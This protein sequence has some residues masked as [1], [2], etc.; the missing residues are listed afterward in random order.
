MKPAGDQ[1]RPFHD[2]PGAGYSSAGQLEQVLRG[3]HF[4]VTAELSP[5]DSADPADVYQRASY[6]D[7][8]VDAI[9]ATDGSGANCH[10]SSVGV[11]SLLTRSGYSTVMQISCRDRNRIAIQGDVLGA[12]A[13]GV[14]NIL[15]LTGDGVQAGDQPDAKG[16]FDFDC[17]S[18]L[19]TVCCMRDESRFLSDRKL[20]SPPKVFVGAAANPYAPPLDYRPYRLKKKIEAGAQF[21][22]TQYCFDVPRLRKYMSQ[23]CDLGLHERCFILVGVGPLVSARAAEWIRTNVPGVCIPD[24]VISRLKS[25]RDPRREGTAVCIELMQE[26]R[27][28]EGV[29]GL[30]IMAYRQEQSIG[31][32]IQSSGVLGGRTPLNPESVPPASIRRYTQ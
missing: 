12:A 25:A 23:V 20:S 19:K 7:G 8:H 13:M 22:Q 1:L 3:G 30:H 2:S 32:I 14:S 21:V 17:I 27:E 29:S 31:E 9:N 16:V 10:M 4:A 15:C 11:C 28:I 18:L 26:I 24:N 6:F 5:P